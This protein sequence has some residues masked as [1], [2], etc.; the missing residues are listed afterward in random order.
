MLPLVHIIIVT[1]NS[2]NELSLCLQAI[3]NQSHDVDSITI[4]DSGS[5]NTAYLDRLSLKRVKVLL[6]ENAGFSKA[7]NI[8]FQFIKPASDDVIVFLNPDAFLH[9]D[10]ISQ[11]VRVF[12]QYEG[13]GCVTGKLNGY[14]LKDKKKTGLLD[15]TG[16]F[17]KWYGRWY[18]RGQGEADTELYDQI[19]DVPA[20]CGALMCCKVKAL[21]TFNREI[22]DSSFFLYKEDIELSLR[23]R[24]NGWR[25]IYSP[26]VVADHCRGWGE[27]RRD[28]SYRN[29][30]YSA[31][32][33]IKL[34]CKHPSIYMVWAIVKYVAVRLLRL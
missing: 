17:R 27:D 12:G 24:R 23:I 22:F 9:E 33:E 25:L 6:K 34:Y 4:V 20:A 7:N 16:V 15:S 19:E 30:L 8:G 1:H 29:R 31:E 11:I 5:E 13:V 18:D 10:A 28:V 14:N 32:N 3:E 21:E 26:L 2:S